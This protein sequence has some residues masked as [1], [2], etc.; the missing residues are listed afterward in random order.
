M[1]LTRR[2]FIFGLGAGMLLD[3]LGSLPALAQSA[4]GYRALV[5]VF[6]YG[7]NDGNNTV[8]P[9]DSRYNDYA[10]VRGDGSDGGIGIPKSSL[11]PL[12]SGLGTTL[13]GLP[14]IL[15]GATYGL[16]PDL[17]DLQGIWNAGQLALLFNAGTLA[18]PMTVAEYRSGAKPAPL[19]LFSHADQQNQM[20]SAVSRAS[21]Y[22]GW[23][24]RMADVMA[25]A[26]GSS[27][28]PLVLSTGGNALFN[29]GSRSHPLALPTSGGFGIKGFGGG[30]PGAAST[31]L[32]QLLTMD[33][34]N[35]PVA[36]AQN[37][38]ALGLASS[39]ALEPV[40]TGNSA[41]D[42]YFD[43]QNT[44]ISNQLHQVARI[45][46][47]NQSLSV[48]RQLFFVQLGGFDT[49]SGQAQTQAA[50]FSQLGPAL[51]SFNDAMNN[52]GTGSQVTTFSLSDFAR[53]F[54]P[55]S[56]G[57]TDHA[58]GNHHFIMGGAVKGQ[59]TY[60]TFPSLAIGGA[61]DAAGEGRWLPT[62]ALDQYGATLA[63][64]FGVPSGALDTVFPNLG[65]F[66][67]SDLGFMS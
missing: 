64:W 30:Y 59:Q 44:S 55:N 39:A 36:A 20:Q 7:G 33:Q 9:V 22:S 46:A 19:S 27:P 1:S 12:A 63:R 38:V 52:I 18:K 15:G 25:G 66:G 40:L 42:S 17:S 35:Q 6:L 14:P 5:C 49:H 53:T 54:Q 21:S 32:Q 43:G 57:G 8:V 28:I 16:H 62:T 67:S 34:R 56:N 37:T 65:S 11:V 41:V 51:K 29:L 50:L 26:N 47:A 24:G 23:G 13:P 60:G 48:Q 45:I 61:D 3:Q 2:K 58:W 10:A 31:A 4:G